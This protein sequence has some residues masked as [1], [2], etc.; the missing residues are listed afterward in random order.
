MYPP[1]A[2]DVNTREGAIQLA[3]QWQHSEGPHTWSETAQ[4]GDLFAELATK[5]DLTA[6]FKENGL[7]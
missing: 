2:E 7:L 3:V 1:K 5:F 4:W 6:E